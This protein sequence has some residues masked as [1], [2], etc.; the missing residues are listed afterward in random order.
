MCRCA[1]LASSCARLASDCSSCWRAYIKKTL[2]KA[3]FGRFSAVSA[4]PEAC[5][6]S[7]FAEC[8]AL[9]ICN[10]QTTRRAQKTRNFSKREIR[11]APAMPNIQSDLYPSK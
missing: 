11:A 4:A 9:V 10:T 2:R 8:D 3:L 5:E 7:F 1:R 6:L